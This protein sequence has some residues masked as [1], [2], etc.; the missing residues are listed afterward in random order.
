MSDI[1]PLSSLYQTFVRPE[2]GALLRTIKLDRYYHRG[3]GAWLFYQVGHQEIPVLDLIGGYGATLFGHHHPR[4]TAVLKEL[5]EVQRPFLAQGSERLEAGELAQALDQ[6]LF[7]LTGK[8]FITVFVNSGAEAVEVALKHAELAWQQRFAHFA[9]EW[10]EAWIRIRQAGTSLNWTP[11]AEVRLQQWGFELAPWSVLQ[12]QLEALWQNYVTSQPVILALKHGFHGK[13]VAALQLTHGKIYRTPFARLGLPA[14]FLDPAQPELLQEQ[15]RAYQQRW[16]L[17]RVSWQGLNLEVRESSRIL[18]LFAEPLQGEGG[19]YPISPQFMQTCREI[20]TAHH[21]PLIL[22]EIQSGMG[23]T[24][25][26]LY[27]EQQGVIADYYLLS[28]SLGG[29]LSKLGVVLIAQDQY[30]PEF[31]LLHSSTFSEDPYS[32]RLALESLRLLE[33]EQVLA[34]CQHLGAALKAGFEHLRQQYPTILQEVRGQGLMLGLQFADR[35]HTASPT[36]NMLT[37][38][39]LL[40]YVMA[41][42]LLE[43]HRLRV[44]PTLSNPLT[45]RLEPSYLLPET[46][47][48]RIFSAFGALLECLAQARSADLLGFLL[49]PCPQ[50]KPVIQQ[51]I[52]AL[53]PSDPEVPGVPQVAF[54]GH[55]IQ[56]E[57]IPLWDPSLSRLTPSQLRQLLDVIWPWI[58]PQVYTQRR[59]QSCTGQEVLLKF[60]GLC[61]DSQ[62]MNRHLRQHRLQPMQALVEE[63]VAL[64]V[65]EGCQIIGLGGYTSIITRN[66]TTLATEDIGITTGNALTVAMGIEALE[67]EAQRLGISLQTASLAVIGATGN[68]ASIYAEIMAEKVPRLYLCGRPGSEERLHAVANQIYAQALHAL[69]QHA[70]QTGVAWAL[71]NSGLSYKELEELAQDELFQQLSMRLGLQAPVSCHTDLQVLKQAPLILAASNTPEPVIFPELLGPG[72][73]VICDISMPMDTAPE[74]LNLRPDLCIIRGGVV[75]LP[76]NPDF[77]IAGIPLEPGLCFA[78]MAETLLLGLEN[79]RNHASYGRLTKA[80]VQAS[81]EMARRHGFSLGRSRLEQSF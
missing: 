41:A 70:V 48:P 68:I 21:F 9:R 79:Q 27:S 55:F 6:K 37:R 7:T 17:P 28:K 54:V 53:I 30:L 25:T 57:H 71:Q 69:R 20:A 45:L 3:E 77:V 38:Q 80:Q 73:V 22:D 47:L 34:R 4:L 60:I 65:Q 23:R 5:L 67:R 12:P 49:D 58:G 62:I 31:S 39:G 50:E 1:N 56:P 8:H 15:I 63:A 36:L 66:G 43:H 2:L 32:A 61:V 24:G 18:A 33:E 29:G 19:I 59:V 72:P 10:R 64:A 52:P 40:G 75:S 11:E 78:C 46:E 81:L 51:E 13:T 26:F 74:L 44:A 35:Q 16:L 42:W 14:V 76:K